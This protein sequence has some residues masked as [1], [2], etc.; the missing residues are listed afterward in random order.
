M[1]RVIVILLALAVSV[2]AMAWAAV[3]PAKSPI[4]DLLQPAEKALSDWTNWFRGGPVDGRPDW[5]NASRQVLYGDT[6]T[7]AELITFYGCGAC[8][9]IP[10]VRGANGTVGPSLARFADRAYIAGILPNTPGSLTRWLVNPPAHA[11]KTAMPDLGVSKDE[12]QHMAA[13]LLSLRGR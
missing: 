2:G 7:G 13:Y 1:A 4:G 3:P 8:H 5:Q 9:D 12:A 10:G 6:G 11:P